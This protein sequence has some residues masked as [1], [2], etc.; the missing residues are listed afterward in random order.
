MCGVSLLLIAAAGCALPAPASAQAATFTAAQAEEG[1]KA[2]TSAACAACHLPDLTGAEGPPLVGSAFTSNW[3]GGSVGAL[4]TFVREN[5]PAMAPGSLND[6]TYAALVAYILSQNGVASG[7]TPL[8]MEST[9]VITI[10][11]AA[12]R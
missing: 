2:Y 11:A 7:G 6:E 5:M 3:G 9:G 1:A 12:P 4:L 10:D 8:T